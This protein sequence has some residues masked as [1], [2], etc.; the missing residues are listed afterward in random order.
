MLQWNWQTTVAGLIVGALCIYGL[1]TETGKWLSTSSGIITFT[2][3]VGAFFLI[4]FVYHERT[5]QAPQPAFLEG[6]MQVSIETMP[7]PKG[8]GKQRLNLNVNI[9]KRDWQAIHSAG[10]AETILC[11]KPPS[12]KW[13]RDFNQR[14][15]GHTWAPFKI[16]YL[17]KS[18][19]FDF[20]NIIQLNDTKE[21]LINGLHALRSQI[22]AY[23]AQAD[24]PQKESFEL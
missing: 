14:T 21:K 13:E 9:S 10:L 15:Y 20:D 22:D 6:P 24:T 16:D 2:L 19:Q 17:T 8:R 1:V 11:D 7:S 18:W 12:S 5:R 4:L 23:H 3:I